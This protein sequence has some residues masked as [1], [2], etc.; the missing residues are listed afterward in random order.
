MSLLYISQQSCN[1]VTYFLTSTDI[2]G[3]GINISVF[4]IVPN[5]LV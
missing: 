5:L 2:I 1:C 3:N 4:Y